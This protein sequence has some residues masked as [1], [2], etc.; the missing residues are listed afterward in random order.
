MTDADR[1]DDVTEETMMLVAR[2]RHRAGEAPTVSQI[3]A[4]ALDAAS[5][6]PSSDLTAA[7]IR[8]IVATAAGKAQQLT[9]LLGKLAA[10]VPE[11]GGDTYG[12]P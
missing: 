5:Q 9:F 3:T 11:A 4:L 8:Q 10:L 1:E 2:V 12:Q 7:E 6:E